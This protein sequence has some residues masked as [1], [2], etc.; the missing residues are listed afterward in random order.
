MKKG[1]TLIELL[2]VIAIIGIL[3]SIVL[4]SLSDARLRAKD[5]DFKNLASSINSSVMMCCLDEGTIQS[6]VGGSICSLADIT[7]TYP[8]ASKLGSITINSPAGGDCI[9]ADNIYDIV[10][11]PGT[12]NFGNCTDATLNQEGVVGYTGC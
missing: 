8:D 1:F 11:T 7:S 12:N 10:I 4:V 6:V 2:I 9:G 3:A 5:A